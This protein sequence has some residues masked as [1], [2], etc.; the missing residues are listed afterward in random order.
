MIDLDNFF[1][2]IL[3]YLNL[4]ICLLIRDVNLYTFSH[5]DENDLQIFMYKTSADLLSYSD[6]FE[7][8]ARDRFVTYVNDLIDLGS[9]DEYK[10]MFHSDKIMLEKKPRRLMDF[11]EVE[12]FIDKVEIL[13]LN[14]NVTAGLIPIIKNEKGFKTVKIDPAKN[15]VTI[16][17]PPL[18]M[19]AKLE[20]AGAVEAKYKS[21]GKTLAAVKAQTGQQIR[22]GINNEYIFGPDAAKAQKQID[23]IIN[24]YMKYSQ[25]FMMAKTEV[26]VG[27]YSPQSPEEKKIYASV[28]KVRPFVK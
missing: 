16:H 22:A 25:L 11:I 21:Y 14:D 20:L 5:M 17:L 15:L 26:I 18:T 9:H 3:T 13:S 19:N 24:H 8:R 4:E 27:K 7:S 12:T 23:S 6:S 10:K 28:G 2:H 1:S